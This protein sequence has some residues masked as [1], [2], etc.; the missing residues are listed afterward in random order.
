MG[1][2]LRKLSEWHAIADAKVAR[3]RSKHTGAVLLC[4]P[5]MPH[6]FSALYRVAHRAGWRLTSDPDKPHDAAIHWSQKTFRPPPG[7]AGINDRCVDISK[8]KVEQI[9]AETFGY[10]LA[11][12]AASHVGPMVEKSNLNAKH[13]GRIVLGPLAPKPGCVYERVID[14]TT[15]DGCVEDL[16]V[17]VFGTSI[18]LVYRKKRRVETRFSNDN[19]VAHLWQPEN[20]FAPGDLLA[21][22]KFASAIGM[23]YGE[24][25][26]LRDNSDGRIYVVDAN[27]TP[28]GP[29][30]GIHDRQRALVV[31]TAAFTQLM[32]EH[33]SRKTRF[34]II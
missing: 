31:M 27:P 9:F 14:N 24:L 16:R 32:I 12:D 34:P 17:A 20:I 2:P 4:F 3:L 25:D 13:D 15:A 22:Y 1:G 21:L 8:A 23:D 7:M 5:E 28:W 11:V 18:P 19:A 30:N 10:P 6:P 33:V 29:P 26:V